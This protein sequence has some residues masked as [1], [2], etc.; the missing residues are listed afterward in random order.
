MKSVAIV[1]ADHNH[2]DALNKSGALNE[3]SIAICYGDVH[4]DVSEFCFDE[5]CII[6]VPIN[7]K[8]KEW[9]EGT[10]LIHAHQ[11]CVITGEG[12]NF[13]ADS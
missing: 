2:A 11:G 7:K 12:L 13:R 5:V 9:V 8:E 4:C 3:F 1:L 6:D 10:L